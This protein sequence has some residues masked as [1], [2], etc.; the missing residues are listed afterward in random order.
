MERARPPHRLLAFNY[1]YDN[2][3][4]EVYRCNKESNSMR[5]YWII[6]KGKAIEQSESNANRPKTRTIA[7]VWRVFFIGAANGLTLFTCVA[8]ISAPNHISI[9]EN[10]SI[11]IWLLK[12]P[13]HRL[14]KYSTNHTYAFECA[15]TIGDFLDSICRVIKRPSLE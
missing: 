7:N 8:N 15:F 1:W 11:F 13:F 4:M 10:I 2:R 14:N 9:I 6:W 12:T 5:T 3:S